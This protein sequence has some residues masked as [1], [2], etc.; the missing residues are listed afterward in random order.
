MRRECRPLAWST[1]TVGPCS[2]HQRASQGPRSRRRSL[3]SGPRS[4][5][6]GTGRAGPC[7]LGWA[8]HPARGS[9]QQLRPRGRLPAAARGPPGTRARCGLAALPSLQVPGQDKH[10]LEGRGQGNGS[11]LQ[12]PCLGAPWTEGLAGRGPWGRRES[13][14]AEVTEHARRRL[15]ET[16]P[17]LP[18]SAWLCVCEHHSLGHARSFPGCFN[19]DTAI[20]HTISSPSSAGVVLATVCLRLI[21]TSCTGKSC[22]AK[23]GSRFYQMLGAP[24]KYLSFL[25]L[26]WFFLYN[27]I[28]YFH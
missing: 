5:G 4:R 17:L 26:W 14:T 25:Y 6:D 13:G 21:L 28:I 8:P 1:P 27:G 3:R 10:E 19:R 9:A 11:P 23:L 22:S 24:A 18:V 15:A 2:P 16:K 20:K 7:L 12:A